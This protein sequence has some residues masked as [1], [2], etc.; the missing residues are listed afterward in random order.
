MSATSDVAHKTSAEIKASAPATIADTDLTGTF[1]PA[2]EAKTA[3]EHLIDTDITT[4]IATAE[5][6]TSGF[7]SLRLRHKTT[8]KQVKGSHLNASMLERVFLGVINE[9]GYT[10]VRRIDSTKLSVL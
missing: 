3:T 10:Y 9:P 1:T 4:E 2:A 7:E 6:T 5:S 8:Y